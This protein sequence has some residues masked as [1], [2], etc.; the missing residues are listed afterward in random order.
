MEWHNARKH[1]LSAY[2]MPPHACFELMDRPVTAMNSQ[3][4]LMAIEYLTNLRIMLV[5]DIDE[6]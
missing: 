2:R 1:A 6:S 4:P 3:K 5:F